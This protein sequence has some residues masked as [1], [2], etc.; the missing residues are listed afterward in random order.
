MNTQDKS[1]RREF[2]KTSA[3]LTGGIVA[4]PLMS[5]ANFFT[6]ADDTIKVALVGCGG[7]GT[8]AA[9]QACLTKQKVKLG[10]G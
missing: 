2:V 4:M 10:N 8:G 9:M 7:R 1:S 3:I 5:K 6:G